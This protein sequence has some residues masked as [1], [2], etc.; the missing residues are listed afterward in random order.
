MSDPEL[1]EA[2]HDFVEARKK[3]RKPMTEKAIGLFVKRLESL[4]P[5]DV[6]EQVSLVNTAI[7]R[8]W[9]TVYLPRG[10]PTAGN[11]SDS[12]SDYMLRMIES[13]ELDE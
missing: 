9:Q 1:D 11:R 5:G 2:V 4:A 10:E 8:G 3:M 7:E 13:G 12:V 6:R